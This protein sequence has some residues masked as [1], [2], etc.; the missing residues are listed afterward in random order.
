VGKRGSEKGSENWL[1]STFR[2]G[3]KKR[4]NRNEKKIKKSLAEKQSIK[5]IDERGKTNSL[6]IRKCQKRNRKGGWGN[7]GRGG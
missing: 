1:Q 5:K 3:R 2:G 4:A 7:S 6:S